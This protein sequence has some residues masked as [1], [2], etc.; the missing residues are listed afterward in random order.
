MDT[1][2]SRG[3]LVTTSTNSNITKLSSA[4]L[5]GARPAN[6][7]PLFCNEDLVTINAYD[8]FSME[9]T[10]QSEEIELWE[11]A[12]EH[13]E[14][15]EANFK[16]VLH[17]H[18]GSEISFK[19]SFY[20]GSWKARLVGWCKNAWDKAGKRIKNVIAQ[21]KT[22]VI[23]AKEIVVKLQQRVSQL[24]RKY[25]PHVKQ[26]VIKAWYVVEKATKVI[27]TLNTI[28]KFLHG[29]GLDFD[30]WGNWGIA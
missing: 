19:F 11:L 20:K 30:E 6:Q 14:E 15:L 3:S 23:N 21:V 10:L 2:T 7:D 18:F 24:V 28:T 22:V 29:F 5:E 26:F 8:I 27:N 25:Y 4:G 9:I 13:R 12:Q 1:Q 17:E 16:D